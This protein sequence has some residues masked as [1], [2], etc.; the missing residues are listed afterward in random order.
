MTF[1]T[2]FAET[3]HTAPS[4]FVPTRKVFVPIDQPSAEKLVNFGK[5]SVFQK[6]DLIV[7][8]HAYADITHGAKVNLDRYRQETL[9]L[10]QGIRQRAVE[11][12]EKLVKDLVSDGFHVQAYIQKGQ[13]QYLIDE[14]LKEGTYDLIL[15]GRRNQTSL[16]QFLLGSVS[17]HVVQT[18]SIPV[19]IVT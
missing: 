17:N 16:K 19:T 2:E 4:Y 5:K 12:M 13:A 15:M 18:C 10:Q 7:L 1:G 9:E 8:F 14:H 11:M 3:V 6:T